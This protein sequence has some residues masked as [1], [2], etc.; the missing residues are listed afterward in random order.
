MSVVIPQTVIDSNKLIIAELEESKNKFVTASFYLNA[1]NP[2][3]NCP[4]VIGSVFDERKRSFVI[5]EHQLPHISREELIP[6]YIRSIKR[7]AKTGESELYDTE[8]LRDNIILKAGLEDYSVEHGLG[9][10]FLN[11]LRSEIPNFM[12]TYESFQCGSFSDGKICG[13]GDRSNFLALEKIEGET[14]AKF[15]KNLKYDDTCLLLLQVYLS[16]I[17]ANEKFGYCHLDLHAKNVMVY[18]TKPTAITYNLKSGP[19]TLVVPFIAVIIDYGS[20]RVE[21]NGKV[22]SNNFGEDGGPVKNLLHIDF[23]SFLRS[24]AEKKHKSGRL[25]ILSNMLP[26]EGDETVEISFSDRIIRRLKTDCSK[27]DAVKIYTGGSCKRRKR[28]T[29][30]KS[31]LDFFESYPFSAKREVDCFKIYDET[32]SQM[33]EMKRDR[34]YDTYCKLYMFFYVRRCVT[35]LK[36]YAT[37]YSYCAL[38]LTTGVDYKWGYEFD[39]P[40]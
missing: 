25:S 30:V 35:K 22:L 4:D 38:Y 14:A 13:A 3:V 27:Y 11:S 5:V 8:L 19:F 23:I 18:K 33:K 16:L 32:I 37:F 15:V 12:Q 36:K 6:L 24:C 40:V 21:H 10:Y 39:D 29:P 20:S 31:T 2:T 7:L 17:V 26:Y 9:F 1:E 34:I 28:T